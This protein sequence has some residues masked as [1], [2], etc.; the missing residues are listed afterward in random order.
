MKLYDFAFSPNCRK[1]RAVAYELGIALES[2]HVDLLK[3]GSRTPA[4]LAVNPNGRVPVLVDDDFVLWESTAILRYLSAKKGGALVPT[5]QR[6]QAEVDRWLA[7][8][9]AHL[10]PAMSKVAFERIV[11][12]LTG[13]G[14]PDETAVALGRAEFVKL[15][16][17][18]DG[19]LETRD[20]L[21]ETLSLADFALAAQ[22][23]LA[24]L[25]GLDLAPHRSVEAW[26]DRVLARDSMK[27]A[28]ADAHAV[29][30]PHAA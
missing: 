6:G 17:L 13:Q 3:G 28:L 21:A 5:T 24:P 8:Q 29:M 7:W 20:Y 11:K 26:L 14:E 4:F 18:L 23:S 12:K 10:G 19:A 15:T 9:L 30:R 25:C 27:L 1:V 16:A 2:V 22:Y